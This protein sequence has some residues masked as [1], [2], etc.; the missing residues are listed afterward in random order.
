MRRQQRR[1][2]AA[3]HF[4]PPEILRRLQ[5]QR[6]VVLDQFQLVGQAGGKGRVGERALAE[7]VDGEDR[8]LV[9]G[10]Q[11]Q[12]QAGGELFPRVAGGGQVREQLRHEGIRPRRAALQHAQG[13]HDA[14]A[15]PPRQLGRRRFGEGD[16]KQRLDRQ[17]ALEQQ[18]QVEA[19]D[20]PGL[21][22][23]GRG[24]DQADTVERAGEDVEFG[25]G[26]HGQGW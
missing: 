22:G 11:R 16:H 4:A 26:G 5:A 25:G 6:A 20:V 19:A 23:A 7:A 21:A 3:G 15:D 18:A 10:L 14:L 17:F 1:Q 9:E 13:L 2:P 12:A 8:R 24:L